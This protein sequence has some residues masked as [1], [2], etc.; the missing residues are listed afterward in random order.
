MRALHQSL[1]QQTEE[2]TI[3]LCVLF[4][5]SRHLIRKYSHNHIR[6]LLNLALW[7]LKNQKDN[8]R[9]SPNR[10]RI[11][12]STHTSNESPTLPLFI[13]TPLGAMK[14][15]LPTTVPMMK[16]TAGSRPISLRRCTASSFWS[17]STLVTFVSSAISTTPISP[18]P[19]SKPI[20]QQK[21]TCFAEPTW[22]C[23]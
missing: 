4:W 17:P 11:P 16:H 2:T 21:Q 8:C 6:H 14:M 5:L 12:Q 1:Y 10:D 20:K 22:K 13:R 19:K 18:A 23:E 15:P 7:Q 3:W 9:A